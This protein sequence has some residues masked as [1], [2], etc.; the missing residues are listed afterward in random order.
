MILNTIF[1]RNIQ[2]MNSGGEGKERKEAAQATDAIRPLQP[3]KM[4]FGNWN[5]PPYNP[6]TDRERRA[7]QQPTRER[8]GPEASLSK[9]L[10]GGPPKHRV[11]LPSHN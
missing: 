3:G 1:P 6:S 8:P 11:R 4:H 5:C 9:T 2:P 10:P 7:D